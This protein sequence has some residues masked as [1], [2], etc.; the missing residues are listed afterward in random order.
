[1]HCVDRRTGRKIWTFRTKSDVDSSPVVIGNQVVFGST[2]GR[3]YVVDLRTGKKIWS[4]EIG[5]AIYSSPAVA[6]GKI[7]VGSDDGRIYAFG[8]KK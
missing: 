2:D 1:M 5:E 6:E 8:E 7:V 4:Y 3:V